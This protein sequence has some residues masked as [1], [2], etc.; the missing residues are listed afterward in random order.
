M[1]GDGRGPG[2][3][4]A[5]SPMADIADHAEFLT[6]FERRENVRRLRLAILPVAIFDCAGCG[7][8]IE[9]ARKVAMPSARRCV[10]CEEIA[11]KAARVHLGPTG[12]VV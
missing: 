11:E 2:H 4:E 8:P 5:V 12:A 3:A 1:G 10:R 9:P 7:D 6:D